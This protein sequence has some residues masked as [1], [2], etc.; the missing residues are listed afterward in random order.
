VN[1]WHRAV[2]IAREAVA[3]AWSQPVASIVSMVIVAGMCATVLLTTGRTVGAEQAVLGS[4]DSAGTRSIIVRAD[5]D[6]G[7]TTDVLDR[8]ANVEGIQW[9]GAFGG[10]VDVQ[11]AAVPGG[12][13]VPVRLAWSDDLAQ[14]G[15]S[16]QLPI[17][18]KSALASSNAM[19]RL[20]MP[21]DAGGVVTSTGA[22][23]A[24]VGSFKVPSYLT[25]LEPL[26]IVPQ[27]RSADDAPAPVSVLV[28][29]ASRPDLVAPITQAVTSVLAVNDP[30]KVK[31]STSANLATLRA[32]IQGQLGSFGRNLVVV[33]FTLTAALVAAILYGLVMLRRKDF[34]RRRALGASQ[35][36]IVALLLVQMA[37]LSVVGAALGSMAA[38]IGLALGGDPLP[39]LGFF[40]A[41]DVLAVAVGVVAA[42]LPAV[43][44]ARR[45]PLKELRVP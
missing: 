3:T 35:A 42:L 26:V 39:N 6:A 38:A 14:L 36:L 18:N 1:G 9:A 31:V 34:G 25:F 33:I 23:Y 17:A 24:V 40:V 2:A 27:S 28:V 16:D 29:I 7:L 41:V 30:T 37:A 45:D 8:L 43:A 22:D 15:I 4:I 44:A 19:D 11:N 12:P 13:K 32:L 10:A 21:D 5:V 20:G